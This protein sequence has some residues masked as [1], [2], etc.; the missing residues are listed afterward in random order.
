MWVDTEQKN[1]QKQKNQKKVGRHRTEEPTKNG[2]IRK[3]V[4]RNKKTEICINKKHP[5]AKHDMCLRD[6][7]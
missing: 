2:K 4:G 7:F 6:V 3:N 5:A 1:P